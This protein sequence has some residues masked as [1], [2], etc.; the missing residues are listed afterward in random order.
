MSIRTGVWRI[1]AVAIALAT[2]HSEA[3][4]GDACGEPKT[5]DCCEPN[6]FAFCE[7]EEC[8]VEVCQADPFCCQIAWDVTCAGIAL[9]VCESCSPLQCGDASAGACCESNGTP[10]CVD[11]WCCEA[12]CAEDAFCCNVLWDA[13][14]ASRAAIVCNGCD[15]L[16]CR[17]DLN[18]DGEVDGADLV[19]ALAEWGVCPPA[20][21]CLADLT[22]DGLVDGP[23]LAELLSAWGAC[24]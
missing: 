18:F 4:A 24:R 7:D 14:C 10:G 8:C 16:V 1:G 9:S 6:A 5:G 11:L 3:S 19:V 23:D 15:G 12:V 20:T 21:G 17:A 13:K 22:G 2:V